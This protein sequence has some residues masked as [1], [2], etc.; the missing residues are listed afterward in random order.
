MKRPEKHLQSPFS[1][2]ISQ[3]IYGCIYKLNN[4]LP[5]QPQPFLPVEPSHEYRP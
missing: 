5:T 3:R 2:W 1:L 4:S